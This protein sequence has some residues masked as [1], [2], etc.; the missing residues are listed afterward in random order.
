MVPEAWLLEANNCYAP[1]IVTASTLSGFAFSFPEIAFWGSAL[2]GSRKT[3]LQSDIFRKAISI[4]RSTCLWE[5]AK[6]LG[7]DIR[8][9]FHTNFNYTL[10]IAVK[11]TEGQ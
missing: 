2:L 3:L 6:D 10:A 1:S 7:T 11:L 9:L 4:F 5:V 8:A